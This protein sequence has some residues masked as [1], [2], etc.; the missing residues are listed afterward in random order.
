MTIWRLKKGADRRLRQ[1]H[2]WAFAS[3]LAHSAKEIVPGEVI[4]LRDGSD[5]FLAYGYGH[6]TSQICFRK[7]SSRSK[8]SDVLTAEFFVRRLRTARDLRVAAGWTEFS[9]RWL[10]AEADGVPGLIVDAFNIAPQRWRIVVQASTAGADRALPAVY[11][12]IATFTK[13][14][15][16]ISVIEAPSS[17][18]RA[19]EGL[20]ILEK[21]VVQGSADALSDATILLADGMKLRCDLLKGQKTGFF[22]DQQWNATLL[23]RILRARFKGGDSVRV[24]DIC[25]YV[26]QWAA[27][28][29]EALREVGATVEVSLV[30]SSRAALDLAVANVRALGASRVE[31]IEGDALKVLGD[32]APESFDVVIC[33]PPAFVKKKADLESGLRAY[34]KLNRDALKAIKPGGIYVASSCSGLVKPADFSRALLEAGQKSGRCFKQL[35][36]GGHGPDHPVRPE[37]PEGEYL[38]CLIGRADLPF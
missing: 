3:E 31:A 18:S 14:F 33:D 20:A 21:K 22:L 15:G 27:H 23:K 28:A 29:T 11:E 38:K 2:P 8:E 4:E 34:T 19:L 7:L 6:P 12:A 13:E 17:R 25:C 9:H 5:H 37:F 30:D 36:Q 10:Y 24:L 35:A 26:G 32:L 1:G 16:E